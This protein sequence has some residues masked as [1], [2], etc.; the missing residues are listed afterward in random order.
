MCNHSIISYGT[1]GMWVAMK[2]GGRTIVY[3]TMGPDNP[4]AKPF[5]T[6]HVLKYFSNWKVLR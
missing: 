1:F 6:L 2:A 4:N 5:F 3:D